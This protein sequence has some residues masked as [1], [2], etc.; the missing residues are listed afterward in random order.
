MNHVPYM[1]FRLHDHLYGMD[2]QFV[3]E[4]LR[5]PELTVIAEVPDYLAGLLNLRGRVVPVMDLD[6]RLGYPAASYSVT[7][8]VIVLEWEEATIGIIVSE[9]LDVRA[10]GP[11]EVETVRTFAN[12]QAEGARFTSKVAR[13]DGNLVRILDIQPV[14]RASEALQDAVEQ[15]DEALTAPQAQ[16]AATQPGHRYFCPGAGPEARAMFAERAKALAQHADTADA[17][18]HSPYA[19]AALNREYFGVELNLVQEFSTLGEVTPIPCSP[20]HLAGYMNLRG[21]ILTLLDLRSILKMP[22]LSG[23]SSEKVIVVRHEGLLA[24]ILVDEVLDLISLRPT[25][26]SPV[27]AS[28]K[29]LGE[30]LLKGTA[31]YGK[32][33]LSV[34]N[35]TKILTGP[36]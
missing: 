21:D 25:D 1:L 30:G 17:S 26:L 3:R 35:L 31:P 28:V 7:D 14:I 15:A 32:A 10:V 13:I 2:T 36:A 8:H 16:T 24:G 27:P 18:G 34:L 5:L 20:D 23:A 6:K 22:V 12:P 9:V 33:M 19:V 29:P 11:N 4:V